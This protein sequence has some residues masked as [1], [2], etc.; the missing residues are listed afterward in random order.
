MQC[1]KSAC[2]V[3]AKRRVRSTTFRTDI[4]ALLFLQ[5]ETLY[6]ALHRRN[7]ITPSPLVTKIRKTPRRVEQLDSRDQHS[8]SSS[9]RTGLDPVIISLAADTAAARNAVCD[10]PSHKAISAKAQ[11][12]KNFA[13]AVAPPVSYKAPDKSGTWYRRVV[14]LRCGPRRGPL[15]TV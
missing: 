14:P 12:A 9:Q 11:I 1:E 3:N 15:V 4:V 13:R 7:N 10:S 5:K 8:C 6:S 2:N